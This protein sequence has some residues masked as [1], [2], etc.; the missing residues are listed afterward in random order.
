MNVKRE[1]MLRRIFIPD[2]V[3][4]NVINELGNP[5]WSDI[6]DHPNVKEKIKSSRTLDKYLD[7]LVEDG[8]VERSTKGHSKRNRYRLSSK[9]R[10][11]AARTAAFA[12]SL[13]ELRPIL[14]EHLS[15][16]KLEKRIW[17][18]AR[19][20]LAL[21]CFLRQRMLETTDRLE[22]ELLAI[23]LYSNT[24]ESL[25]GMLAD[26]IDKREFMVCRERFKK[27]YVFFENLYARQADAR[28]EELA[29][30]LLRF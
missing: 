14:Q 20:Q 21:Q 12:G 23:E 27:E 24:P 9:A 5:K 7:K 15:K 8:L 17:F 6:E 13:R 29:A 1:E 26:V 3:L 18:I 25:E 10:T 16:L 22:K 28:V 2:Q 4:L 11:G 30:P 19:Y